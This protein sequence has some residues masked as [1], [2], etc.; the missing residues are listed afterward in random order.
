MGIVGVGTTPANT[1]ID[2]STF[3]TGSN[4]ATLHYTI[5]AADNTPPSAP[6]GVSGQATSYTTIQ[7]SWNA[8]T[9]AESGIREYNVYRNGVKIGTSLI[10]KIVRM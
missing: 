1:A 5:P 8:A 7:L 2:P 3:F 4:D 9:D 10:A 6:A